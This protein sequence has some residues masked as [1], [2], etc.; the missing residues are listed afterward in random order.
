MNSNEILAASYGLDKYWHLSIEVLPYYKNIGTSLI[1]IACGILLFS[2]YTLKQAGTNIEP[3]K[4]TTKIVCSGIYAYTRNPIYL[5]LCLILVGIGIRENSV[6]M[7]FCV[8]PLALML[9]KMVIGKEEVYLE[10]KFG[11][12]YMKYKNAVRPWI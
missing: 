3:T 7:L 12:E 4:P 11:E 2:Q 1:V 6:L 8:L 9:Q 10:K 5:A